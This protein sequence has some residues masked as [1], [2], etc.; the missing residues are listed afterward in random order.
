MYPVFYVASLYAVGYFVNRLGGFPDTYQKN[1]HS[2][3]LL[4]IEKRNNFTNWNL[5]S[6]FAQRIHRKI[7]PNY[8]FNLIILKMKFFVIKLHHQ[9][10]YVQNL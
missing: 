7:I 9:T 2:Q 3:I 4:Y 5:I 8:I 1:I 10:M 6:I